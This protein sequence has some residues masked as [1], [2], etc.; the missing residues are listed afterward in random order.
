METVPTLMR[1]LQALD[2][3]TRLPAFEICVVAK[4]G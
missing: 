2:K 4:K 1:R 3:R